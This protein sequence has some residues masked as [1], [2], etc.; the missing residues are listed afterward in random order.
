MEPA[1]E[2]LTSA[3]VAALFQISERSVVRLAKAGK[4][5]AVRLGTLWRFKR[6]EVLAFRFDAKGAA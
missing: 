2:Y 4:L 3:Q 1:P 5:P 6:D